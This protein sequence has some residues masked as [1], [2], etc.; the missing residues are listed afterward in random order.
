M[1]KQCQRCG[2]TLKRRKTAGG[3]REAWLKFKNRKHCSAVCRYGGTPPTQTTRIVIAC[4]LC[5]RPTKNTVYCSRTC[6]DIVKTRTPQTKKQGRNQAQKHFPLRP[7]QA[8]GDQH[9]VE[10]HHIDGDPT[11]NAPSNIA[12]LC[13]TCHKQAH[14]GAFNTGNYRAVG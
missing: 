7:C 12:F 2:I 8:C 5:A 6:R 4:A 10:R 9:R 1:T 13:R 14:G 11:H 3:N